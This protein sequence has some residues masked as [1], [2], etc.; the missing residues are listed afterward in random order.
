MRFSPDTYLIGIPAENMT[1]NFFSQ[2]KWIHN[3]YFPIDEIKK[4]LQEYSK[5]GKIL[6]FN[7][8]EWILQFNDINFYFEKNRYDKLKSC[9]EI[10]ELLNE[11]KIKYIYTNENYYLKCAFF[12]GLNAKTFHN[13]KQ[14]IL[15]VN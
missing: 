12:K 13:S 9:N 1:K 2:S 14:L 11:K 6:N 5:Y 15:N 10:K 3:I 8:I 4:N 7:N